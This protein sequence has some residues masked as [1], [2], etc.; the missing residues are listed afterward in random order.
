M[1]TVEEEKLC[2]AGTP[3]KVSVSLKPIEFLIISWLWYS[4]LLH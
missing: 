3:L 4:A 2:L 1:L